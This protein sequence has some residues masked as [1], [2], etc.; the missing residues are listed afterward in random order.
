MPKELMVMVFISAT[1]E[2][3]RALNEWARQHDTTRSE[4]VRQ[5]I[6]DFLGGRLE[7]SG[8]GKPGRLVRTY[9]FVP[10]DWVSRLDQ[11]AERRGLKRAELIRRAIEA[12]LEAQ[13][14]G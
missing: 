1:Q 10:Q 7:P 5:A 3:M 4:V 8:N 13:P 9:I 12:W 6:Q 2:T 11:E 14:K